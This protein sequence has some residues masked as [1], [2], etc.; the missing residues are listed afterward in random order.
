MATVEADGVLWEV[1]YG[2]HDEIGPWHEQELTPR[3][4][5]LLPEGGV[6]LD[7]GAH[8]GHYAIRAAARASAVYAVEPNP[9]TAERLRENVR[10]NGLANV[11]V[12]E[13]AAWD[14]AGQFTLRKVHEQYER[15]GSNYLVP[16]PGG[17]VWG[18]R[19]DDAMNQYPLRPAR[20]DLVKVDVEGADL[21][22]IDGMR[23]LV[24]KHQ[25][26]LFIEDHSEYGYYR[27][28]DLLALIASLG[29][30]REKV[31]WGNATYWQCAPAPAASDTPARS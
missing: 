1:E 24:A 15:D 26:V 11:H 14:G 28:D 18:A 3:V 10:L 12:L 5:S 22:A 27:Q 2:S 23:G 25:P 13:L 21:H 4:L 7:V 29:Y 30:G 6:F 20:L 19:L 8:V 16:S 31:T 9:R 17:P